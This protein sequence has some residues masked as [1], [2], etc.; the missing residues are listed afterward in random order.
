QNR[1]A[2]LMGKIEGLMLKQFKHLN[3]LEDVF[4]RIIENI[5]LAYHKAGIIHAD[6]SEYNILLDEEEKNIQIIDWPQYITINHPNAQQILESDLKNI[7]RFFKCKF[8]LQIQFKDVLS[9]VTSN[10]SAKKVQNF[11]Q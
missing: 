4:L 1:H 6:L 5:K 9:F 7:L 8:S 11:P 10:S 2:V 3:K